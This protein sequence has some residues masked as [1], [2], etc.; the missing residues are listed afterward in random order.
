MLESD[1]L[2]NL[3]K[4]CIAYMCMAVKFTHYLHSTKLFAKKLF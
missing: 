1:Y 3:I 2:L 4:K